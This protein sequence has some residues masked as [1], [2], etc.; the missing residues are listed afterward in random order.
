M[1]LLLLMEVCIISL[2]FICLSSFQNILFLIVVVVV[3]LSLAFVDVIVVIAVH[4]VSYII[5]PHSTAA[6][7]A[8]YGTFFRFVPVCCVCDFIFYFHAFHTSFVVFTY[9]Y[10]CAT[11][12]ASLLV[13]SLVGVWMNECASCVHVLELIL[14]VL[15]HLLLLLSSSSSSLL[16]L[17]YSFAAIHFIHVHSITFDIVRSHV[18]VY[19]CVHLFYCCTLLDMRVS[20]LVRA[21]THVN[22]IHIINKMK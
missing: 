21:V 2:F 19:V 4:V 14:L 10:M 7:N 9:I 22:T 3:F 15:F 12:H 16:L 8:F 11:T 20:V 13:R 6:W 1:L 5:P 18:R 17:F